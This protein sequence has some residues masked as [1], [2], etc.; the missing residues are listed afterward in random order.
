[1][2]Q[3]KIYSSNQRMRLDNQR[4]FLAF[5]LILRNVEGKI[6]RGQLTLFP[7]T[8]L[9]ISRT[10]KKICR[11]SRCICWLELYFFSW[12]VYIHYR[13]SSI[14]IKSFVCFHEKE[15]SWTKSMG[16]RSNNFRMDSVI[17]ATI[18]YFWRAT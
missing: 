3:L 1:M 15:K 8:F 5:L 6:L 10:A 13:L 12:F 14:F 9:R 16:R 18:P 11:L 17:T 4:I 2:N 7:S